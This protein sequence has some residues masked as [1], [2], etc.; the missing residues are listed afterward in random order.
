V[1]QD[2]ET[3]KPTDIEEAPIPRQPEFLAHPRDEQID[4]VWESLLGHGPLAKDA[5]IRTAAQSL[6]DQGLA[7]FQRLREG[8]PLYEAIAAALDRGVREGSFDRPKRGHIRAV[9]PD[10]KG[11]TSKEWK[12]CLLQSLDG[13]PVPQDDALRIAAEWARETLGLDFA[14]LRE[15]GVILTGLSTALEEAVKAGEVIRRCGTVSL[16]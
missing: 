8:G 13:E 15:D 12:L 14:R 10:A 6:R 4:H 1:T 3:R 16:V 5:A 9:L 2:F 7:Q 11:Y